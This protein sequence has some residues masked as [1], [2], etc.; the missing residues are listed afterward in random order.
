MPHILV[1]YS[2]NLEARVNA[3]DL[4]DAL[5]GAVIESGLFETAAVRTRALP[6]DVYRIAGGD[7]QNAFLHI[8]ARIRAGRSVESRKAL[9]ESLL[10]AARHAISSLPSD[11]PIAL[12]VEVHEIDPEM[13]FRHITI[14]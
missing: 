3:G 14:K 13:L 9:G 4:I 5:H 2:R 1:E 12:S 10:R 7:P 8:V 11:T 6:R